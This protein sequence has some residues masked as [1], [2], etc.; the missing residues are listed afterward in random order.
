V[1]LSCSGEPHI[2]EIR[3]VPL[4][5][6]SDSATAVG[7]HLSEARE[8]FDG[9][10]FAPDDG[11]TVEVPYPDGSESYSRT[12]GRGAFSYSIIFSGL[13]EIVS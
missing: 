8:A 7:A 13:S 3:T 10:V 12:S 4:F 2:T 6:R 11:Q 1:G 5:G 9:D